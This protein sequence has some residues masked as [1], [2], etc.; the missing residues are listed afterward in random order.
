MT[1]SQSDPSHDRCFISHN[2]EKSVHYLD[3]AQVVCTQSV[4]LPT[5]HMV[6]DSGPPDAHSACAVAPSKRPRDENAS[7]HF[8]IK[9]DCLRVTD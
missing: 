4:S 9:S 7:V 8:R 1:L 5:G 6:A 3:I 2:A